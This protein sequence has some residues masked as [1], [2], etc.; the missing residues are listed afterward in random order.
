M[1]KILIISRSFYPDMSPRSF[2]ATELAKEFARQGHLVT[3]LTHKKPE[4]HRSFEQENKIRISH[5]GKPRFAEVEIKGKGI[6]LILRRILRRTLNLLFEFPDIQL[7]PMVRNAL[8]AEESYD[9]LITIA[10]PFPVHWGTAWCLRQQNK[11]AKTWVADCGDP[12]MGAS[13]DTFRKPAYFQYL[14]NLFLK[15]ADYISVPFPEMIRLFNPE[16]KDKFVVIPQGLRFSDYQVLETSPNN[17]SPTFI[18]AGTIIPNSRDPFPLID[19]LERKKHHYRF[20]I[21]THQKHLFSKYGKLL[22]KRIFLRDYIPRGQ[23]MQELSKA[24]FLINI[25]EP[26]GKDELIIA[27]PSKLM[28]YGL[29]GRPILCYSYNNIPENKIEQFLVKDYSGQFIIEDFDR[30]RIEKVC[31]SFLELQ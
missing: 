16:F 9:L 2:R 28:D 31:Q 3:V 15:T 7:M 18:Y 22:E 1:K 10:V 26:T 17:P 5:L 20:I 21:Y 19:Y 29:S 25:F 14:E 13:S 27:I 4:V 23:L 8:K 6:N 30:F 11:V 12:Y 24:D